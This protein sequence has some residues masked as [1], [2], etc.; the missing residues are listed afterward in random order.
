ME[1]VV[2]LELSLEKPASFYSL[3]EAV[4]FIG[5]VHRQLEAI[6]DYRLKLKWWM[7]HVLKHTAF[8]YGERSRMVNHIADRLET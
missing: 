8:P 4:S 2:S 6:E 3:D 5:Q 7:G 1:S